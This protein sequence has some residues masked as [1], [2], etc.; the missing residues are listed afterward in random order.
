MFLRD[1]LLVAPQLVTGCFFSYLPITRYER[2][3]FADQLPLQHTFILP[4]FFFLLNIM[5][6]TAL[7]LCVMCV[8]E[9][10]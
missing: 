3:T 5:R 4:F 10:V 8:L 7:L 9:A 2:D 1:T 6:A